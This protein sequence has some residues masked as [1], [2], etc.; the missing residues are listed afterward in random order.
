VAD[1][2]LRLAAQPPPQQAHGDGPSLDDLEAEDD[3]GVEVVTV[4][5]THKHKRRGPS[6]KQIVRGLKIGGVGIVAGTL[7]AVTGG[8]AAPAIATGLTALGMG[9]SPRRRSLSLS[10]STRSFGICSILFV[11]VRIL[12][13]AEL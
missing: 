7:L 2:L 3:A 11:M 10:S 12:F 1:R 9:A 6:K 8:M 13:E 5:Q 4:Q